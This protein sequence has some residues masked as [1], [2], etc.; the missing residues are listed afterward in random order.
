MRW[1]KPS[2]RQ[3]ALMLEGLTTAYRLGLQDG[4]KEKTIFGVGA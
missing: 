2:H 4:L 3:K 1:R